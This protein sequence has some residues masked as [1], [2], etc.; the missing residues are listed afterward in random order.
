MSEA[1][2]LLACVL[3]FLVVRNRAKKAWP[4]LFM[5][6][7]WAVSCMPWTFQFLSEQWSAPV[8]CKGMRMP[9]Q[10]RFACPVVPAGPLLKC[11]A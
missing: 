7:G 5:K 1:I 8:A 11:M 6:V 9:L 10:A 2:L 3:H 4:H